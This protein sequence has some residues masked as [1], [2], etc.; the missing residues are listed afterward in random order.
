MGAL[1]EIPLARA[2][3]DLRRELQEAIESG[4]GEPL[5]L[6]VDSI[7]LELDVVLGTTGGADAKVSVWNVL[8]V[9]AS[10]E[11]SREATHRLTLTLT[12]RL[13]GDPPGKRLEISD[14]RRRGLPPAVRPEGWHQLPEGR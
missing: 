3:Q 14:D 8:S 10:A 4:E 2:I 5:R 9:G 11:R 7:V 6:E 1:T 13:A 12:P